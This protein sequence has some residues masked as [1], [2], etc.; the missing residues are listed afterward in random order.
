MDTVDDDIDVASDE[1]EP[2]DALDWFLP[3]EPEEY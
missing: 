1:G 3:F 2:L